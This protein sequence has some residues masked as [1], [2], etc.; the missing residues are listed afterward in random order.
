VQYIESREALNREY[1]S[2]TESLKHDQNYDIYPDEDEESKE[3]AAEDYMINGSNSHSQSISKR[4][5]VQDD[6]GEDVELLSEV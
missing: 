4:D 3:N 5:M 6:T 1:N 2:T